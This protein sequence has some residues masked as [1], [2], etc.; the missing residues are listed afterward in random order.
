MNFKNKYLKYK[1]KYINLK[2]K[3][4]GGSEKFDNIVDFQ[5]RIREL[6]G[7]AMK[8][9]LD[10]KLTSDNDKYSQEKFEERRNLYKLVDELC[11]ENIDYVTDNIYL[12]KLSVGVHQ[13]GLAKIAIKYIKPY[14]IYK[15]S[16]GS[17]FIPI[18]FLN[19]KIAKN[20][21]DLD[22]EELGKPNFFRISYNL[23]VLS[24]IKELILK[25]YDIIN[26]ENL[27]NENTNEILETEIKKILK[28]YINSSNELISAKVKLSLDNNIN[29]N[30]QLEE[31]NEDTSKS[32][33][34]LEETIRT[35]L[36]ILQ[37]L[38][39][40]NRYLLVESISNCLSQFYYFLLNKIGFSTKTF[41]I[42]LPSLETL[43]DQKLKELKDISI[44]KDITI[45]EKEFYKIKYLD[46]QKIIE[47][48][49]NPKY[50]PEN[51]K[52]LFIEFFT[53]FFKD[54]STGEFM[55]PILAKHNFKINM[56]LFGTASRINLIYRLC[57]EEIKKIEKKNKL[58]QNEIL[59]LEKLVFFKNF[60]DNNSDF[61]YL[62]FNFLHLS[63]LFLNFKLANNAIFY[64]C[65]LNAYF[66]TQKFN[67]YNGFLDIPIFCLLVEQFS[68]ISDL[69]DKDLN[70][71]IEYSL[72]YG[73]NKFNI[74]LLEQPLIRKNQLE[75]ISRSIISELSS[76]DYF[77]ISIEL[78]ADKIRNSIDTKEIKNLISKNN[79]EQKVDNIVVGSLLV[80]KYSTLFTNVI[81]SGKIT[82]WT[83]FFE[84]I[85]KFPI[86]EIF[87]VK[88][89][90]KNPK[91]K[92]VPEDLMRD[93][94]F[95]TLGIEAS[96]NILEFDYKDTD[97]VKFNEEY[98]KNIYKIYEEFGEEN[99]KEL[100][101]SAKEDFEKLKRKKD[102]E[103]KE[104]K[105]LEEDKRIQLLEE[106]F[107]EVDQ[108]KK[109]N[110]KKKNKKKQKSNIKNIIDKDLFIK[111]EEDKIESETLKKEVS[112]ED[113]ISEDDISEDK[114][115]E[116]VDSSD[117]DLEVK[118]SEINLLPYWEEILPS[119]GQTK[120][121]VKNLLNDIKDPFS[122]VKKIIP[123]YEFKKNFSDNLKDYI[124]KIILALGYITKYLK[125]SSDEDKV[126]RDLILLIKGGK[127][128][129]K[130]IS[131]PSDDI[132]LIL[133]PN[134]KEYDMA[135]L[136]EFA[137]IIINFISWIFQDY[138]DFSIVKKI[139]EDSTSIIKLQI[140]EKDKRY[141]FSILDIGVGFDYNDE[142]IKAIYLNQIKKGNE[143]ILQISKLK[144]NFY[145][146]SL[147]SLIEEREY[148][149]KK[150]IPEI[151]EIKSAN[152]AFLMKSME[153]LQNLL[154]V[155]YGEKKGKEEYDNFLQ[156]FYK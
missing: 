52:R 55:F 118:Y 51:D 68:R 114:N 123:N 133:I 28:N 34:I 134:K 46:I 92:N 43:M 60:L 124:C 138:I 142:Q 41:K 23:G 98:L 24:R 65:S 3:L 102:A 57:S 85:R 131:Y 32:L 94:Y 67:N 64:G 149:I 40:L 106:L 49:I 38:D 145:F 72:R 39:D 21:M 129:Q 139:N 13:Q 14:K 143:D 95:S 8:I 37:G 103:E 116:K 112:S 86:M 7:V 35:N 90:I 147:D 58:N 59:K 136:I 50:V 155:K 107:N 121:V 62:Y 137:E 115:L 77:L 83:P 73:E 61:S 130:Y 110:K 45:N 96:L 9:N 148:Y 153:P 78:D 71:F 10:P 122:E 36:E 47:I 16:D 128:L 53:R 15:D 29:I 150:Y 126:D 2:K 69:N 125:S 56:N 76:F 140:K 48:S 26:F 75:S 66:K 4:N 44:S 105:K 101:K 1:L 127:A 31:K 120:D 154:E 80:E 152:R 12:F 27:K 25:Q 91:I 146:M 11:E 54:T 99:I 108:K 70:S 89:L 88:I 100:E 104:S 6:V 117:D 109:T 82:S 20:E 81:K 17:N 5:K 156:S 144:L 97:Y 79:K 18:E 84:I 22:E 87:L 135:S 42:N 33:F 119:K 111:T 63:I 74:N 19:N 113:D 132:D 93:I 30:A 141:F 151:A